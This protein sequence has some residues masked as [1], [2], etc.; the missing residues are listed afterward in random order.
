[1]R[2]NYNILLLI[3]TQIALFIAFNIMNQVDWWMNA[4]LLTPLII[5][6]VHFL[7]KKM[8]GKGLFFLEQTKFNTQMNY[9]N[10]QNFNQNKNALAQVNSATNKLNNAL[11]SVNAAANN[12]ANAAVNIGMGNNN[13]MTN[14]AN[15]M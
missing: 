15:V 6:A 9:V 2:M 10:M 13:T 14:T 8:L 5:L 12:M 3:L 1:M 4:L 7:M 11:Q